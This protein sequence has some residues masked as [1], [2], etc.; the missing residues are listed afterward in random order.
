M[1]NE[2]RGPRQLGRQRRSNV[3]GG[4]TK[5]YQVKVSPEEA[6]VLVRL[7]AEHHV[8]VQRFLIEAAMSVEDRETP[9]ERRD[10]LAE[11]FKIHRVLAAISNNVNQLAKASNATGEWPPEA[12][13]TLNAVRRTA[14]RIDQTIDGLA[15]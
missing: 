4:R 1:T 15:R 3:P 12:T 8:S 14:E 5:S 13:G 7:A 10:A 11:L 9:T 2:A 6:A